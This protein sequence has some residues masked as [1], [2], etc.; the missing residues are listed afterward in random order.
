MT[1]PVMIVEK[2]GPVRVN[3]A[4]VLAKG[5]SVVALSI[6]LHTKYAEVGGLSG[7]RI[8]LSV[9]ERTLHLD[10]TKPKDDFT[11][12]A[13][14]AFPGYTVHCADLGRYTL[15]VCLVHMGRVKKENDKRIKAEDKKH[16][17]KKSR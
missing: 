16:K 6:D 15:S 1:K 10:E 3:A 2:E 13:F 12:I 11:V 9:T 5:P 4:W 7:D 8:L 14:P 17:T